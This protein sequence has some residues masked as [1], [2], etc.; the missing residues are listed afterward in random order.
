MKEA[1][2]AELFGQYDYIIGV[3]EAGRG[4]LA[5]PVYA[6]AVLCPRWRFEELR[7]LKTLTDSKKLSPKQRGRLLDELLDMGISYRVSVV[8]HR[9]IDDI[10][11]L[12]AAR[13][14]MKRAVERLEFPAGS[15]VLVAV[16]GN[17]PIETS[18]SQLT[19]VKGDLKFKTIA[20][21]SIFAKVLR[22]RFMVAAST[23]WPRYGFEKHKG[24]PAS[25]HKAALREFG[26]CP[27]H[28]LTFRGV[29]RGE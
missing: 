29:L 12:Q 3:D 25:A 13:L 20:A 16:D 7:N 6:G 24:Y 18:Y 22:D 14:G 23:K 9:I 11:I 2:E 28:R 8:N 15:S 26:P 21:A 5:G 19:V 4:C 1:S 17:Q 27:I 10:N